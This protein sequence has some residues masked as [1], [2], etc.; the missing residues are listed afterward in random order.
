MCLL[1]TRWQTIRDKSLER[2]N[3]LETEGWHVLIAE[4]WEKFLFEILDLFDSIFF[5]Q[6]SCNSCVL[7]TLDETETEW[8][9]RNDNDYSSLQKKMWKC[10]SKDERKISSFLANTR[11]ALYVTIIIIAS[12]E[13]RS[14]NFNRGD[15]KHG[16]SWRYRKQLVQRRENRL[17]EGWL[18]VGRLP[19][20]VVSLR[21]APYGHSFTVLRGCC[22]VFT[23]SFRAARKGDDDSE[24]WCRVCV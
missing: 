20:I 14:R 3:W 1:D 19:F 6:F 7:S 4:K 2:T 22:Y 15:E 17:E 21:N 9:F 12:W 18:E 16:M 10:L 8:N 24:L 13:F 11:I 5:I 23:A